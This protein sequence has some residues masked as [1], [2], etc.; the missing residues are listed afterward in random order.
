[1]HRSFLKSLVLAVVTALAL[2]LS[3]TA[4][5]QITTAGISGTLRTTEGKS[6]AGVTVTAL[7]RPTN[8]SFTAVTS[9]AGRFTFI[10]LPVGGPFTVSAHTDAGDAVDTDVFTEL[11]NEVEI[12]LSPKSET[13]Q[14]EKFVVGGTRN[15]LDSYAQGSGTILDRVQLDAKP[16]SER[17][18]ADLVSA[19]PQVTLQAL[20][21]A[22]DREEAHIVAL[23]QNNRF[24]SVMIDGARINDVF[25]LNGSGLAA[26]FN[27]ISP[28]TLDQMSVQVSPYPANFSFFTGA[29]INVVTKSGSND[30][31]GSAYYYFRG[32]QLYGFQLQGDNPKE[33]AATGVKILPKLQRSTW[34]GTFSG[35]IWK[36]HIFF[37]LN[38]ENYVSISNG[39]TLT[40]APATGV[41]DQILARLKQYS[42][43]I[44]W[45]NPVTAATSNRQTEKKML[46]KVDWKISDKHRLTARYSK[47]DGLVPQFGNLG[48]GVTINGVSSGAVGA[49]PTG[50]FY[51]QTRVGKSYSGQFNS[52]WTSDFKTELRFTRNTDDQLTPTYSTAPLIVINGVTGTDLR[53]N[54]P[55]T[56]G[57]Y[58]AGTEQFRHGNIINVVN[59]QA[60]AKADYFWN[61]FVFTGGVEREWSD[62][63]NLFRSGSYGLV[64]FPTLAGFLADTGGVIS[65]NYYDP[66]VRPVSD[67]SDFAINSIYGQAKWNYSNRLNV[68]LGLRLDQTDTSIHPALN[69]AFLTATGFRNDGTPGGV[70]ALAPR[71]GFNY[72]LD[73]KRLTQIHG[74]FG[75]FMGRSPWVFFSNSFGNTGVGTFSRSSTDPVNALTNSL[76]TYLTTQFDGSNPIGSGT[77]NPSLRREVDFNDNN[78]KMPAV[79]RGNLNIDHKLPFLNSTVTVEYDYTKVAEGLITTNENLKPLAGGLALD[80][81]ARFSGTPGTLANALYPAYTNMYRVSNTKVG[82]S[83]YVTLEWSRPMKDNWSFRLAYTHG[84]S[85]EAQSNSQTTAGGQFLRNIVFNQNTVELS[86]ADYEIKDRFQFNLSRQFEFIK[87]A[88]TTVSLYYEGRSGNP[89]S[90]VFGGDLNGDGQT[91]ND[92]VVIPTGPTD[93]KFD[94]TGMTAAQQTAFFALINSSGLSKYAGQ[95]FVPKNSFYEPWV[96]RLDLNFKQDIPIHGS[97]KLQV[98][99]DFVNFGAFLSK[100]LFGYTEVAP[101]QTNDAFRTLTLTSGTSY[102]AAGQIKPLFS[103]TV[104][105][106]NPNGLFVSVPNQIDNLQSRWRIQLSAKLI[107]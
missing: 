60:S 65:R 36:D 93:P 9:P 74:G 72:S 66:A 101:N 23:G 99:L 85:T 82:Q 88:K 1:M 43:T 24:N 5:A 58:V 102:N 29:A 38:Y 8:A 50:H 40:F 73:D 63:V 56:T 42:S 4:F 15:D 41:E 96:N 100:S 26:F 19:T 83:N 47:T 79:W 45:G 64:A 18:F 67:I 77:D 91:F 51:D 3:P 95:K 13:V 81:R 34:G 46:A 27:P 49:S 11:G 52:D 59:R 21:S 70:S 105:A 69:Q 37:F 35:P 94:F 97:A 20:S 2:T 98:G 87:K 10:G 12:A 48:S 80:G 16:S 89:E 107:F 75:Y 103:G 17:S 76:G 25:G 71:F 84:H 104:T 31:H 54:T 32:D 14:L 22:N 30:F 33:Q 92:T 86:T 53:T 90:W 57:A 68:T 78:V 106:T 7:H 6:L 28:D 55:I 61:D 62:F 39:R 44:A